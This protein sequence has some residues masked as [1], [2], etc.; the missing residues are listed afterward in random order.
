MERDAIRRRAAAVV[1]DARW[2]ALTV[3]GTGDSLIVDPITREQARAVAPLVAM[4]GGADVAMTNLEVTLLEPSH[5][6][7]NPAEKPVRRAHATRSAAETL[8]RLGIN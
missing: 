5:V 1:A 3:V 8:R 6:P 2:W 7:E 4:L